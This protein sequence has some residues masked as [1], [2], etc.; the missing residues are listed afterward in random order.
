MVYNLD[1]I[2]IMKKCNTNPVIKYIRI[3]FSLTV[4]VLGIIHK[5]WL[6]AIGIITLLSAFTGT[7][8]INYDFQKRSKEAEKR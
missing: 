3:I 1:R 7:C 5:T 2:I 8:P 4:I 6:G